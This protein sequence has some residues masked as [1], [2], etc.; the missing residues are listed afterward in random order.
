MESRQIFA[1]KINDVSAEL[2]ITAT[3]IKCL[4]GSTTHFEISVK[5]LRSF[6]HVKANKI[7]LNFIQNDELYQTTI[8]SRHCLKILKS[9][10]EFTITQ[11]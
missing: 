1:V 6:L 5:S 9:L 3:K 8:T 10:R 11:N 7:L 4:T 2:E